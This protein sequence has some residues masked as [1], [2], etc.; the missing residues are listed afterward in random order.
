M[1]KWPRNDE[2]RRPHRTLAAFEATRLNGYE[3]AFNDDADFY[4]E[5]ES[6]RI[7]DGLFA[8]PRELLYQGRAVIVFTRDYHDIFYASKED[9]FRSTEP[10]K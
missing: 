4:K 10:S 5:T 3:R 2:A 9:F 1:P 7:G 6:I 8:D